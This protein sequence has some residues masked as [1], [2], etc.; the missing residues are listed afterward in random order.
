MNKKKNKKGVDRDNQNRSVTAWVR[1]K[2]TFRFRLR[3]RNLSD[4]ELGALLWLLNLD[5]GH[6]H[7]LGGAKPLGFGS[8]KIR[9]REAGIIN[10]RDRYRDLEEPGFEDKTEDE[11]ATWKQKYVRQFKQAMERAYGEAFDALANIRDLRALLADAQ[12]DLPTT[13]RVPARNPTRRARISNGSWGTIGRRARATCCRWHR[14]TTRACHCSTGTGKS[15][16]NDCCGCEKRFNENIK[17]V[18]GSIHYAH[19]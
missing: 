9:I 19:S 14:M 13:T 4:V 5:E 16:E 15:F 3:V 18:K 11:L 7:R 12:P 2:T 17:R 6:Y 8:V 1:P 10:Y